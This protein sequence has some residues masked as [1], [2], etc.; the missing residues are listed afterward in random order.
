MRL[1]LVRVDRQA[2]EH[3]W[4]ARCVRPCPICASPVEADVASRPFCSGR[5]QRI[6]LHN[7][8]SEVYRISRPLDVDEIEAVL[9]AERRQDD[10]D[11]PDV[12]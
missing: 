3:R 2:C 8:L 4:Y 9:A 11:D 6:D 12:S 10:P 5:C 7:W 1:W